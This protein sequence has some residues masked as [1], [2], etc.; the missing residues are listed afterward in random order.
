M[1]LFLKLSSARLLSVFLVLL[2][3]LN[4]MHFCVSVIS[5]INEKNLKSPYAAY[6]IVQ[7]ATA[8]SGHMTAT[9]TISKPLNDSIILLIVNKD[10]INCKT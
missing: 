6:A 4:S 3:L 8:T 1:G 10:S 5:T 7:F 9:Y 2:L